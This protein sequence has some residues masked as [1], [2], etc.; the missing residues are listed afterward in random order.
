MLWFMFVL[1]VI[2]LDESCQSTEYDLHIH[3]ETIGLSVDDVE[4]LALF[5]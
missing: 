5:C 2:F 3:R 4:L 1:Y